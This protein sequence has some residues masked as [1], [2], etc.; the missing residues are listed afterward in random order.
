MKG[1]CFFCGSVGR[2]EDDHVIGRVR[3]IPIHEGLVVDACGRCN[4]RRFAFFRL[5][6]IGS[7]DPSDAECLR[8]G[9]TFLAM[10]RGPLD[11]ELADFLT[12]IAES[13]ERD[14]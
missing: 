3:G 4:R 5:A 14:E 12:E 6:G 8:R 7:S 10:R 9:A 11:E 1:T 13:L 2:I